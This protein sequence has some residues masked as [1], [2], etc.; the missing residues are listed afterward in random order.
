MSIQ[1]MKLKWNSFTTIRSCCT[2]P[3][4]TPVG[5]FTRWKIFDKELALERP[6]TKSKKTMTDRI[7][8][9]RMLQKTFLG[10]NR[11]RWLMK[12]W[13][14]LCKKLNQRARIGKRCSTT[15]LLNCWNHFHIFLHIQNWSVQRLIILLSC[16]ETNFYIHNIDI[17][18]SNWFRN[19][20]RIGQC[21]V[22]RKVA[23]T[24]R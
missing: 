12:I 17:L 21:E 16:C 4:K 13:Q 2:I 23:C 11:P 20:T 15:Y 3:K 10:W 22:A 5:L 18:A 14:R 19:N 7:I 1:R 6:E 24:F 8:L 9:V